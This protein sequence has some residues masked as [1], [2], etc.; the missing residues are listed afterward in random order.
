MKAAVLGGGI[1]GLVTAYRLASAGARVVLLEKEA[2]AGGLA[3][4]VMLEGNTVDRYFHFACLSDAAYIDLLDELGLGDRLVWR[5]TR[6]GCFIQGTYHR[7]GTPRAL[8]SFTPLPVRDRVRFG[9][10]AASAAARR[11]W[12]ELDGIA[13]RE[14]LISTQGDRCYET[15]WRPLLS[16]KFGADHS[17]VS[18]AWMW[19]RMNR[20]GRSRRWLGAQEHLG[21]LQGG[22]ATLVSALVDGLTDM[23]VEIRLSSPAERILCEQG[24]VRGVRNEGVDEPF[25]VVVSTVATPLFLQMA[26]DLPRARAVALSRVRYHGIAC[27]L[28]L[29]EAPLC[30][31]FW[32]NVNDSRI[33]VAGVV[34][35][36]NLDGSL[37][38][39]GLYLHYIPMYVS[40]DD[41]GW[42]ADEEALRTVLKTLDCINP[43]FSCSIVSASLSRDRFAQPLYSVGFASEA[44]EAMR[45]DTGVSGLYR[46][47]MSQV[48]PSD[49]SIVN[50][51][52]HANEIARRVSD[53]HLALT[54][55]RRTRP[56]KKVANKWGS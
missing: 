25:D 15:I 21:Y 33:P 27:W 8:M 2:V 48:Y 51:I 52:G 55:P 14:W 42:A 10:A 6:M 35:Y 9:V 54:L 11:D 44:A 49:R 40:P 50:A 28:V 38:Q 20:L 7:F 24:R 56:R 23:G 13:A 29:S 47:D 30:D 53:D 43:G 4:S 36:A 16:M 5:P 34:T 26:E 17:E 45:M 41:A 22:T 19:S 31:D 46:T 12:H 1:A 32:L 18:A 37:V 39:K 3:S